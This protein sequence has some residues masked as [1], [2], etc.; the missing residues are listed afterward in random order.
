[1][2]LLV[3]VVWVVYSPI[4]SIL[5]APLLLLLDFSPPLSCEYDR[6]LLS[7]LRPNESLGHDGRTVGS[8]GCTDRHEKATNVSFCCS[9]DVSG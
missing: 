1:M 4:G 5:S 6:T 7:S 9:T 2:A 8:D 3:W